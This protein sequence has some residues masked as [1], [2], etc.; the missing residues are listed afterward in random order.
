LHQVK[1]TNPEVKIIC[2]V[3][4]I[5]ITIKKTNCYK[6]L[7][8]KNHHQASITSEDTETPVPEDESIE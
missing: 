1:A 6:Q 7:I 3:S 4:I 2:T 8:I 5:N